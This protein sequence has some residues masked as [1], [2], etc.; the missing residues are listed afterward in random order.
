[1]LPVSIENDL[2]GHVASVGQPPERGRRSDELRVVAHVDAVKRVF[3]VRRFLCLVRAVFR[4]VF[5][6]EVELGAGCRKVR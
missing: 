4:V 2:F 5:V 3:V 1:M 6:G